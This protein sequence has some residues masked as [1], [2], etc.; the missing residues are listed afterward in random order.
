LLKVKLIINNKKRFSSKQQ[1][2]D[3]VIDQKL[4]RNFVEDIAGEE[5][6]LLLQQCKELIPSLYETY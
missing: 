1:K 6:G 2:H 5:V 3:F 4:I